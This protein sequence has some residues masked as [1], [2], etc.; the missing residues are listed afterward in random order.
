MQDLESPNLENNASSQ[1]LNLKTKKKSTKKTVKPKATSKNNSKKKKVV[2]S[3]SEDNEQ[4]DPND[5]N[6]KKSNRPVD[7]VV[8]YQEEEFNLR[9]IN[10]LSNK[11]EIGPNR[12]TRFERARITGAR[13]LQ[14][15]LG[16]PSLINVTD[17]I[18]N[19]ISIAIK[20]LDMK[21][22]PISIRRILPNG[23]YQDI[24]LDWM[25]L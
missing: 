21:A 7:E 2:K 17:D 22:L 11:I 9:E 3:I 1:E 8:L 23:I 19:S 25:I 18:R 16:A 6:I 14:L 12:L 4:L 20:E 15:S 5:V 24:P 10:P 13:A